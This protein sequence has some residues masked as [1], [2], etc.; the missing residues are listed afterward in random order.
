MCILQRLYNA[1]MASRKRKAE[2]LGVLLREALAYPERSSCNMDE[3]IE[4]ILEITD[5]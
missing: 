5:G 2:K 3:L 1:I 4:R